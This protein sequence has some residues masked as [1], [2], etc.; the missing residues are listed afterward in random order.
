MD[1]CAAADGNSVPD[2][3]SVQV[4]ILA[5]Q[6][7]LRVG[8]IHCAVKVAASCQPCIRGAGIIDLKCRRITVGIEDGASGEVQLR[9]YVERR[10]RARGESDG[11]IAR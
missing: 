3:R 6:P 8:G 4:S 1:R 11:R 7:H 5:L 10:V 9:F 2:E